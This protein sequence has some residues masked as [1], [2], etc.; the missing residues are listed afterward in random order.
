ML[1]EALH[2]HVIATTSPRGDNFLLSR[3]P[4]TLSLDR[5][6]IGHIDQISVAPGVPIQVTRDA[7]GGY[8]LF[9]TGV[10]VSQM[11]VVE[12]GTRV[13]MTQAGAEGYPITLFETTV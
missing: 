11:E 10:G 4:T 2:P 8:G 13:I 5:P 9:Q 12:S 3:V 6:N 1:D 7:Y